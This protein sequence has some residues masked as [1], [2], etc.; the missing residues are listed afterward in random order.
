LVPEHA[1]GSAILGDRKIR[2]S[3]AVEVGHGSAPRFA[4]NHHAR[5]LNR[6]RPEPAL[7][8]AQ[9]H[10]THAGILAGLFGMHGK[11]VLTQEGVVIPIPVEVGNRHPEHGR[12]LR[13]GGQ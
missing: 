13:L 2:P 4:E 7:P 1:D 5:F 12:D 8:I 6:C 11:E 9:K 3:I 10:D